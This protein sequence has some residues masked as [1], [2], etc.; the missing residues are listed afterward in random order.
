M[1]RPRRRR[2]RPSRRRRG[3]GRGE[4]GG[5]GMPAGLSMHR[6]PRSSEP[7]P[8]AATAR[9]LSHAQLDVRTATGGGPDVRPPGDMAT[10]GDRRHLAASRPR[11]DVSRPTG[12]AR[13]RP[14]R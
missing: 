8:M 12:D 10:G 6:H 9:R 11:N 13:E 3:E 14:V 2:P 4:G 1:D 7:V 5:K